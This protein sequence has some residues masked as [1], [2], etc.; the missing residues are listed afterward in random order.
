[1]DLTRIDLCWSAVAGLSMI[2]PIRGADFQTRGLL[3]GAQGRRALADRQG[4]GHGGRHIGRSSGIADQRVATL[5]HAAEDI[6]QR[7]DSPYLHGMIAMVRG[8]GSLMQGQWKPAQ[9]ALDQAEQLF[10]NQC[11]GVT[12][13]RDTVHNFVLWALMQT[14]R[15]RRAE[16]P[17]DRALPRIS[18]TRRP[19]R[20]H[21]AHRPFT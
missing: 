9:T 6:A 11:T 5:L 4:A 15:S 8:A 3:A 2:E 12:W 1:M 16:T 21:H 14:G 10:R 20:G 7:L 19:L 18:G 13:E 17:L